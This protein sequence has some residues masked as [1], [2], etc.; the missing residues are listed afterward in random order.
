MNTVK[1]VV[2]ESIFY[3]NRLDELI[4]YEEI[5]DTIGFNRRLWGPVIIQPWHC[6]NCNKDTDEKIQKD[7]N[8]LYKLI[9]FSATDRLQN[10]ADRRHL[11]KHMLIKEQPEAVTLF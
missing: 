8:D 1:C 9:G 5:K 4:P 6:P 7:L 11:L 3:T 10:R 2:C